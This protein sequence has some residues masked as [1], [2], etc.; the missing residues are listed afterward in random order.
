MPV[1]LLSH[2]SMLLH[3]PGGEHPESAKRLAALLDTLGPRIEVV[4]RMASREELLEI[5]AP[6]YVDSVL[7]MEAGGALD[8]ETRL[9]VGSLEAA[10]RA[11]GIARLA[12]D[13]LADESRGSA[14]ALVRPPGHHATADQ[15]MGYCIFNNAALAVSRALARG[16]Q[17]V[18]V[19]DWD[20][21]HG[22]GTQQLLGNRR[23]TLVIDLHQDGLFPEG[24]GSA[25]ERGVGPGY[26]HIANV[27][28]P[29]E[30][31]NAE[32]LHLMDRL[33]LPLAHSFRP[34]FVVVSAGFDAH[35]SDGQARLQLDEEG[36]AAMTQRLVDAYGGPSGV[37]LLLVLEGGY[38]PFYL[39]R[40]VRRCVDV[41][42]GK[43]V[44]PDFGPP[45]PAVRELTERLAR[46]ALALLS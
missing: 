29:M 9:G 7:A 28:L 44:A 33:V 46:E 15:G 32:Y 5:H 27:P 4:D 10:Q 6:A 2:P 37:P 40:S 18:L 14:F 38:D 24:S 8:D 3:A 17:R 39:A 26:G 31:G 11:A 13:R 36:Y 1:H 12:V 22:N 16:F 43:Q 45:S 21:H 25:N 34:D 41:L 42:E 23:E 35:W 20:A 19:L 30:V